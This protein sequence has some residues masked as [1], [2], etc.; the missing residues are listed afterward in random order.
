[1]TGANLA[2]AIR[3]RLTPPG[4]KVSVGY[5]RIFEVLSALASGERV[6][7]QGLTGSL[8]FLPNGDVPQTQE[9]FC[10]KTEP[11]PGGS[12]G[13]VVGVKASGMVSDA[14]TGMV[15]GTI[16]GCPGP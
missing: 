2:A 13:K 12:F 1:V 7:L 5:D 10:M 16:M 6:D 4:R 15:T 9:V 14:E 3:A 8:D 11:G